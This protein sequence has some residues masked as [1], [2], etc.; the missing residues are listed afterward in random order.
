MNDNQQPFD[1]K[2]AGGVAATMDSNKR[3]DTKN[4]PPRNDN[5]ISQLVSPPNLIKQATHDGSLEDALDKTKI[6]KLLA[7][8]ES[9]PY[10]P[11][12]EASVVPPTVQ[13]PSQEPDVSVTYVRVGDGNMHVVWASLGDRNSTKPATPWALRD[14]ARSTKPKATKLRGD[15][16]CNSNWVNRCTPNKSHTALIPEGEEF[17]WKA[18]FCWNRKHETHEIF[19]NRML[20]TFAELL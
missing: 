8:L 6:Q 1:P 20:R 4:T 19:A 16:G 14:I 11:P 3:Q 12:A 5:A 17:G 15:L 9:N 18:S 7:H 10:N 13:R 2:V